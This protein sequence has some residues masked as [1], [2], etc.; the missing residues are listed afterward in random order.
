[1]P[2]PFLGRSACTALM[3]LIV[4]TACSVEERKLEGGAQGGGAGTSTDGGQGGS[5][6][7]TGSGPGGSTGQ[8]GSGSGAGGGGVAGSSPDGGGADAAPSIPVLPMCANAYMPEPPPAQASTESTGGTVTLSCGSGASDD[9][10]FFWVPQSSGYY[11]IDT[12]GS[13]FDTTLGVLAADCSGSELS[14][15]DD[16]AATA[17]SEILGEFTAG[18][19][20][21][22]VVDGKSGSYGDVVLNVNPISCPGI[23]LNLQP[24]PVSASTLSGTNTHTG[25]CGG[26]GLAEVAYRYKAPSA[27]L[28]RFSVS[29]A[30]MEPALYLEQGPR[31]GGAQLGCSTGNTIT[32]AVVV[33]RLEANEVVTL[34][35]DSNGGAGAFSLNVENLSPAVCPS[36][37]VLDTEGTIDPDYDTAGTLDPEGPSLLSGSCVPYQV[38]MFPV[39][40]FVLADQSYSL[41]TE[42]RTGGALSIVTD[43]PVAVYVIEGLACGGREI[44]CQEFQG[45]TDFQDIAVGFGELNLNATDHD[46]VIVVEATQPLVGP[47]NYTL[48]FTPILI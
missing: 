13:S 42:A 46:Y 18:Q 47:V 6:A 14:C 37:G 38:Q 28:Y 11:A 15:S 23:D 25:T 19:G 8:G 1:M 33:R 22:L 26:N 17:Q 3:S 40:S 36:N 5:G 44:A 20:V 10:S 43:G 12:F 9:V 27:G 7:G 45:S 29:S 4:L 24:L 2:Q 21:L 48:Y 32:P 30:E 16:A 31:C 39:G 34:I 35:V 41:H